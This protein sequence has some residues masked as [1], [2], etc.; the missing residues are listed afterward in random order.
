M[1]A[2]GHDVQVRRIVVGGIAIDVMDM[3]VWPQ[4]APK[5][6]HRHDDMLVSVGRAGERGG[7][8]FPDVDADIPFCV[9]KASP[10]PRGGVRAAHVRLLALW[11]AVLPFPRGLLA[12]A[13]PREDLAAIGARQRQSTTLPAGMG[14]FAADHVAT[15][16]RARAIKSL[17][18]ALHRKLDATGWVLADGG[19]TREGGGVRALG[20]S[21]A[22]CGIQAGRRAI[23]VG[24]RRAGDR[25]CD[26]ALS[27]CGHLTLLAG[28]GNPSAVPTSAGPRTES[29]RIVRS[30][31]IEYGA[32]FLARRRL[33]GMLFSHGLSLLRRLMMCHGPGLLAQSPASFAAF[34]FT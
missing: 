11:R 32:A 15:H 29:V 2:R 19:V 16:A 9:G 23:A 31:D 17:R 7:V 4:R 25:E 20:V 5:R 33:F 30:G 21:L 22:P 1:F 13:G 3:L 28:F 8:V 26:P 12:K 10:L 6:L 18:S 34:H 14:F 24:V 27:A